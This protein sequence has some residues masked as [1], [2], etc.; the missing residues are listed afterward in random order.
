MTWIKVCIKF[1]MEI[2]GSTWWWR[3]G[4]GWKKFLIQNLTS[5]D[6]NKSNAYA[7]H[8]FTI[9]SPPR[10]ANFVRSESLWHYQRIISKVSKRIKWIQSIKIHTRQHIQRQMTSHREKIQSGNKRDL[11]VSLPNLFEEGCWIPTLKGRE[12]FVWH[13]NAQNDT[14]GNLTTILMTCIN[15]NSKGKTLSC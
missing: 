1:Q 11:S 6:V 8:L 4:W 13:D 9:E 7:D 14:S 2:I 3:I 15:D 5:T 12:N 10:K